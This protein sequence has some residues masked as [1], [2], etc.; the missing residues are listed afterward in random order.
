M[1]TMERLWMTKYSRIK[2]KRSAFFRGGSLKGFA[3][4]KIIYLS[5]QAQSW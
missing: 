2:P 5:E 4:E 3:S 1:K